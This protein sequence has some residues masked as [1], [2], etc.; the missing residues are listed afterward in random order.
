MQI[1]RKWIL[2]HNMSDTASSFATH[3]NAN[4]VSKRFDKE[5]PRLVGTRIDPCLNYRLMRVESSDIYLDEF[6][7]GIVCNFG[8]NFRQ[9]VLILLIV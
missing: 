9:C 3:L 8:F 2:V 1:D 6:M 5:S 7:T 4:V